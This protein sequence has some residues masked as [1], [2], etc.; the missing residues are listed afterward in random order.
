MLPSK[1][2]SPVDVYFVQPKLILQ[3][4]GEHHFTGNMHGISAKEYKKR[5]QAFDVAAWE[6]SM[7]LLRVHFSDL[8]HLEQYLK[9]AIHMCVQHPLQRFIMYSDSWP[10]IGRHPAWQLTV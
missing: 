10:I 8:Q 1:P 6:A 2:N 5:D 3:I 7:R 4:D 9:D